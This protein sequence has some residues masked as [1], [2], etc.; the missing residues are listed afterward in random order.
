MSDWKAQFLAERER[1]KA[2][3][4][5]ELAAL[6]QE[7]ME[8]H[9]AP[10]ALLDRLESILDRYLGADWRTTTDLGR[11]VSDVRQSYDELHDS[12]VQKDALEE[13]LRRLGG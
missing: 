3:M 13:L 1:Q 6:Q 8:G 5:A 11:R 12:V 2:Q 9:M 7:S 4:Q 10:S